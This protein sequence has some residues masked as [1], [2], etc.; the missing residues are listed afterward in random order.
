MPPDMTRSRLPEAYAF[1]SLSPEA[2][3]RRQAEHDRANQARWLHC[4]QDFLQDLERKQGRVSSPQSFH[5][6]IDDAALLV[7]IKSEEASREICNA[8]LSAKDQD[9]A[10]ERVQEYLLS[11]AQLVRSL[12]KCA[13]R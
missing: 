6:A 5:S 1:D 8:V 9:E 11:L 3:A 4:I 10:C 12:G 2:R 13:G 7:E